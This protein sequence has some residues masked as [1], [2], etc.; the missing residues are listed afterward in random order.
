MNK[1]IYD[2]CKVCKKN[3]SRE[4]G[5]R[6]NLQM[7]KHYFFAQKNVKRNIFKINLRG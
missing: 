6:L 7:R 1:P 2:I 5:S 3:A 4:Y